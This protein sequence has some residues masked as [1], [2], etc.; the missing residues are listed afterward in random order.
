MTRQI[1]LFSVLLLMLLGAGAFELVS[2]SGILELELAEMVYTDPLSDPKM[3]L[4]AG[5]TANR[6][7]VMDSVSLEEPD[8]AL[9]TAMSQVLP[10]QQVYSFLQGPKSWGERRN[11][12]GEWSTESIRGNYF[13]SFGCGLCC[14]ANVYCTLTDHIC[15]PWDMYEYAKA[16]SG[17]SPTGRAGAIGW[18]DM[19][20]TLQKSGFDCSLNNKPDSYE[21]FQMQ[22][23][24]AQMSVVLVCS[25][26]DNTFWKSTDGHYVT[27]N[28]YNAETDEVFLSD[29]GNPDRNRSWIPLRY[30]Y[31]A[32]KTASQYQYLLVKGYEEENN[33]W[34]QDGIDE[35][36][37]AP[38]F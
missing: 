14:M 23:G 25:R 27:I 26:N 37:V 22:I 33:L 6:W 30:V 8:H 16:V 9:V 35:A 20:I 31:D 3:P 36:W 12:A 2:H 38:V 29:P 21:A 19:K 34:K 10:E 11:W 28:L 4:Y 15:S 18:D 5:V 32:L 13:G 24:Q 1:W 7:N 17:Y